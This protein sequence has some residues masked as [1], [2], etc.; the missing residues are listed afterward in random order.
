MKSESVRF[1][2]CGFV[3]RRRVSIVCFVPSPLVIKSG[4]RSAYQR[5]F[6]VIVCV[7]VDV[8][9]CSVILQH[10]QPGS[11]RVPKERLFQK[12]FCM[13]AIRTVFSC[14]QYRSV[15]TKVHKDNKCGTPKSA[16]LLKHHPWNL[17]CSKMTECGINYFS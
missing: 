8:G 17:N 16:Q 4:S 12:I 11:C 14:V 2:R 1:S 6:R 15:T 10:V 3:C 5:V 7:K 13:E 9:T